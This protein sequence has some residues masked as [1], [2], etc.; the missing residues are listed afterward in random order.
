MDDVPLPLNGDEPKRDFAKMLDLNR[1]TLIRTMVD[2]ME[3]A[4]RDIDGA[5]EDLKQLVAAAKQ[6]EFS[7]RDVAAMKQIAKLRLKDQ[8]GAAKE[9]LEALERIGKAVGFD[10]FDW[11]GVR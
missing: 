5:Q 1:S 3:Q 10:L 4:L 11:G 9:K 2:Q 7:P 8:G 6:H